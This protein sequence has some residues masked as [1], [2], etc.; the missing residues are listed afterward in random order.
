VNGAAI[1][2]V[3]G[4]G[5]RPRWGA[6]AITSL[7]IF[8]VYLDTTILFVAFPSIATSFPDVSPAGLSWILNAYTI[9][10]GALLVPSGQ[11]ADRA[12]RRRCFV[13]GTWVFALGSALCGAAPTVPILVAARVVQAVGAALL[14]PSS[15]ALVLASVPREQRAIAVSVWGAV[16][17]LA[18]AVGPALGSAIVEHA[19]WRWAFFVNLPVCAI[20]LA[21]GSRILAESRDAT[22]KGRTD[23]VG[24]V[25]L[26]AGV[27]LAALS[28]IEG[29]A[30]GWTSPR[31]TLSLGGAVVLLVGFAA[32][33]R[34]SSSPVI[35]VTL[36]RDRN[37]QLANLAM[38]LYALAFNAM[39]LGFVFFLTQVWGYSIFVA[40]LAITPGPLTVMMVAIGSGRVAARRG[41]RPLI[42]IGGLVFA[43]GGLLLV[44]APAAPAYLTFWLPTAII[45]GVGV[46]LVFPNLNGAAVHGLPPTRFGLGSAVN[47]A[48]RQMGS[49]LGVAITVALVTASPGA[50]GI[51]H[52]FA[53]LVVVGVGVSVIGLGIRTAPSRR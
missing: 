19:G 48:I 4:A 46:G 37:F 26:V 36:F 25:L 43:A 5:A 34:R 1:D 20:A 10:F 9:V 52:T 30:W 42:A 31:I 17:A 2:G 6:L 23:V 24:V 45:T 44:F 38:L 33:S 15:L 39:F 49:V 11:L 47:Q 18:A 8:A 16:G 51:R 27:G 53:L 35:D 32:W 40:G 28:I 3:I 7:A 29:P 14:I 13:A 41:H 22:A 12:G 50:A 21:V